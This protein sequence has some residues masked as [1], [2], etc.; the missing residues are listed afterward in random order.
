MPMFLP[1]SKHNLG[2]KHKVT[3]KSR[4]AAVLCD[5]RSTNYC[6]EG[7]CLDRKEKLSH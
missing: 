6:V 5:G 2:G 3:Q 1:V 7:G 4:K